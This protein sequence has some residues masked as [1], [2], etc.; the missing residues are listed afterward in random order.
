MFLWEG[1]CI[2][3]EVW[4]FINVCL[5]AQKE[6]VPGFS[7]DSGDSG[8]R[9]EKMSSSLSAIASAAAAAYALR[10]SLL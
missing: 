1:W 10:S 9:I 3:L 6:N 7:Y 4:L 5:F 2:V 8:S